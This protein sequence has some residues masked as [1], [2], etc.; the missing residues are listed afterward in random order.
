MER[1]KSVDELLDELGWGWFP[2]ILVIAFII[3]YFIVDILE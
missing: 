1:E 2:E 3:T